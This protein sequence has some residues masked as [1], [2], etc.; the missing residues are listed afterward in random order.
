MLFSMYFY[1]FYRAFLEKR[2]KGTAFF[3]FLQV[4]CKK[5]AKNKYFVTFRAEKFGYFGTIS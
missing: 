5:I 1:L 3:S 2:C 4:F